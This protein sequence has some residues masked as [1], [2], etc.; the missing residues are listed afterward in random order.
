M[1][2]ALISESECENIST[3]AGLQLGGDGTEF[4]GNYINKGCYAYTLAHPR[5]GGMAFYGRDGSDSEQVTPVF[6]PKYRPQCEA[7]SSLSY[8]VSVELAPIARRYLADH[9]SDETV[10]VVRYHNGTQASGVFF[11]P[12][13]NEPWTS[14]SEAGSDSELGLKAA[15]PVTF[16]VPAAGDYML[17]IWMRKGCEQFRELGLTFDAN[18]SPKCLY[19]CD[20]C[21]RQNIEM[22]LSTNTFFVCSSD[23]RNAPTNPATSIDLTSCDKHHHMGTRNGEPRGRV[24]TFPAEQNVTLYLTARETCT[25]AGDFLLYNSQAFPTI[26]FPESRAEDYVFAHWSAPSSCTV[27]YANDLALTFACALGVP[28]AL[29]LWLCVR[30][31][32]AS[33]RRAEAAAPEAQSTQSTPTSANPHLHEIAV[34]NESELR[35]VKGLRVRVSGTALILGWVMTCFGLAPLLRGVTTKRWSEQSVLGPYVFWLILVAPGLMLM[36]LAVLPT[37][38]QAIRAIHIA[39]LCIN[40]AIAI[41]AAAGAALSAN[42]IQLLIAGTSERGT[43]VTAT[44]QAQSEATQLSALLLILCM[45]LVSLQYHAPCCRRR[46]V[47]R[48]T[49]LRL[50]ASVRF[51]YAYA[52]TVLILVAVVPLTFKR[53]EVY[54]LQDVF[55]ATHGLWAISQGLAGVTLLAFAAFATP[56][57]R[58]GVYQAL[59]KLADG[60]PRLVRAAVIASLLGHVGSSKD[61][62]ERARENFYTITFDKLDA[63]CFAYEGAEAL[64]HNKP[65]GTKKER[66][67]PHAGDEGESAGG[68]TVSA[69]RDAISAD[70][71]A[72]SQ[73]EERSATIPAA[74]EHGVLGE[75]EAFV[76]HAWIDEVISPGEKYRAL[77]SWAEAQPKMPR[78]WID[79]ISLR[80]SD[81]A[82]TL[83]LLPIFIVGSTNFLMLAGPAYNSRLW[84]ILELFVFVQCNDHKVERAIVLPL[85]GVEV[86]RLLSTF[87]ARQAQ[88]TEPDDRHTLLG[89]IESSFG[90][91]RAFNKVIRELKL[92]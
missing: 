92:E 36:L 3:A 78:L 60:G 81:T 9:P 68:D 83:P 90:D 10:G 80:I 13:P 6:A 84:T 71:S 69:S 15:I 44:W 38:R 19:P 26:S 51:S 67:S 18:E 23:P 62:L 82:Q 29:S 50:W 7:N 4:A 43:G 56:R 20:Q 16:T 79:R 14:N 42:S 22:C 49:L 89:I 73:G 37:D 86:A 24:Y 53:I 47:P 21:Q 55:C 39:M 35:A 77:E 27:F 30:F 59:V 17:G 40:T 41:G 31:R 57:N 75:C 72:I 12:I 64:G 48:E 25:V 2:C 54:L 34:S 45:A 28:L 85:G 87:D 74:H 52:G 8:T 63:G 65:H 58:G 33:A 11:K 32:R 5:Y 76:S 70:G 66:P 46:S 61:A 88:C 91:L 1:A